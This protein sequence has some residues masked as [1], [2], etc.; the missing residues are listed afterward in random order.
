[1]AEN[2]R[3]VYPEN[4]LTREETMAVLER[5]FGECLK[6]WERTLEVDS[7]LSNEAFICA[8]RDIPSTYPYSMHGRDLDPAIVDEFR[9]YRYMD[10]YGKTYGDRFLADFPFKKEVLSRFQE[11][12]QPK[13]KNLDREILEN[14]LLER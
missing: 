12:F 5:F 9:L 11:R 8:I 6:Y 14:D 2:E 1:M 3:K 4:P 7:D 13:E 10:C